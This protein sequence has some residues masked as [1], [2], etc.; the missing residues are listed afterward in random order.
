MGK[1]GLGGAG[2]V[3]QVKYTY[4]ELE[5]DRVHR[6]LRTKRVGEPL[7]VLRIGGERVAWVEG[8]W[9]FRVW[10]NRGLGWVDHIQGVTVKVC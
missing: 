8:V 4:S 6:F 10:V 7:G 2:Q 9:F 3:V 5:K 1:C